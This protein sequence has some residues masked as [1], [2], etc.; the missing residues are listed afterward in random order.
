M[1][2]PT[3]ASF[4]ARVRPDHSGEFLGG[5]AVA[6]Y[7]AVAWDGGMVLRTRRSAPTLVPAAAARGGCYECAINEAK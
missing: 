2:R 6:Q 1:P 5:F 7:H 4:V 3:N